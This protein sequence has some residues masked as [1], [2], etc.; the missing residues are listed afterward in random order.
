MAWGGGGFAEVACF[1]GVRPS[2]ISESRWTLAM[3][4]L[5]LL[6]I[7]WKKIFN[8]LENVSSIRWLGVA[9]GRG[10]ESSTISLPGACIDVPRDRV[11]TEEGMEPVSTGCA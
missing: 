7:V 3:M 2:T 9:V 10:D 11:G 8:M 6:S 5:S 4:G 1:G